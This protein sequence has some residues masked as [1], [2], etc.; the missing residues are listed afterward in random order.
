MQTVLSCEFFL[1]ELKVLA[2]FTHKVTL[3]FLNCV[4]ISE[5]ETL[6]TVLPQLYKDMKDGNADT[7]VC[8]LV[9]YRH[10]PALCNLTEVEELIVKQVCKCS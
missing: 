7:L 9:T 6:L 4:E 5:Q 10:V 8:F 1:T 2:F 3:P